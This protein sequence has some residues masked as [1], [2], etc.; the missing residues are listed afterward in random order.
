MNDKYFYNYITNSRS[1]VGYKWSLDRH[2]LKYTGKWV[3]TCP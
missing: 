1:C 2:S 3:G